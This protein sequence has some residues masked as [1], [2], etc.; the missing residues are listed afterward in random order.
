MEKKVNTILAA[1]GEGATNEWPSEVTLRA[2]ALIQSTGYLRSKQ[3]FRGL[4]CAQSK[5]TI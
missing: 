3:W 5:P 2:L 4:T 1:G